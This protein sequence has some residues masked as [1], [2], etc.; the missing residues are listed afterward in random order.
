[1]MSRVNHDCMLVMYSGVWTCGRV[2][3][4]V[5]A[6]MCV[7][8]CVC[9]CVILHMTGS[10]NEADLMRSYQETDAGKYCLWYVS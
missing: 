7:C 8:V 6:S 3:I 4:C 9:V 5:C 10:I 1:M 2:Y